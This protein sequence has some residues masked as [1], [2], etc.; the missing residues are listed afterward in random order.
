DEVGA[1]LIVI[2]TRGLGRIQRLLLGSV[3]EGVAHHATCPVLVVRGGSGAWPPR[4][5]VIADDSSGDSRLAAD[6]AS[7]IG[8]LYGAKGLLVRAYPEQPEMDEEGRRFE[9]R[10]VDDELHREERLL[11]ERARELEETTGLRPRVRISVGDPA[12]AIL[13]A[14]GE[15]DLIA[16]GSRGMGTGRRMRLGSVS[17]KVLK[18]ARGPV[19]VCPSPRR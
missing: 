12:E 10:D 5:V 1:D 4:R 16:V 6:L 9:P 2:G 3:A 13:D 7:S 19:L 11:E 18:A 14:A 8:A 17:T 15:G